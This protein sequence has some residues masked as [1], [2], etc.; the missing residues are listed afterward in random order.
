MIKKTIAYKNCNDLG[1][2]VEKTAEVSCH[3]GVLIDMEEKFSE[4]YCVS[5]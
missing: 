5:F 2:L 3:N 4:Q 1:N